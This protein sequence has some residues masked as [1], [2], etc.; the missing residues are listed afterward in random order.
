MSDV[1]ATAAELLQR[2]LVAVGARDWESLL[3]LL[4][5]DVT[6]RVPGHGPLA[7]T[8]RG[9]RAVVERY[10]L[11]IEATIGDGDAQP[12]AF[13][14]GGDHAALIQG[15]WV[16]QP[17]GARRWFTAITLVRS[18][19]GRIASIETFVSDQDI[20]DEL[21]TSRMGSGVDPTNTR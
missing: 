19:D 9:C 12:V 18:E 11:M 16:V 5:D 4:S 20:V 6:W 10:Q 14:T 15:N 8:L 2:G 7:G 3:D 17:D 1:P 21:W 13:L